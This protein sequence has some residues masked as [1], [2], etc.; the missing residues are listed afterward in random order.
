M[1]GEDDNFPK[2]LT[3]KPEG[4]DHTESANINGMRV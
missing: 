1:P 4:R 3:G 2:L